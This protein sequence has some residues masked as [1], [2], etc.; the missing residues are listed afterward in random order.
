MLELPVVFLGGGEDGRT[1]SQERLEGDDVQ[2]TDWRHCGKSVVR[3]K[4]REKWV[5]VR[6]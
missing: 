5:L 1:M 6:D 3:R 4:G 2:V